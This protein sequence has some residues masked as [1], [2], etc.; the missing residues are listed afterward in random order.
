VSL[1]TDEEYNQLF[2][3][4]QTFKNNTSLREIVFPSELTSYQRKQLHTIAEK[5]RLYH[6][7]RSEG[8]Q[9]Y[10]VV[11]KDPLSTQPGPQQVSYFPSFF[12]V[13]LCLILFQNPE[14]KSKSNCKQ[15]K[16]YYTRTR[17]CCTNTNTRSVCKEQTRQVCLFSFISSE[18]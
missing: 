12:F 18:I 3:Q 14:S 2:K 8:D 1:G 15:G 6:E 11:S 10:I 17:R 7:S 5:L 4:L 16:G 13:N 9:R